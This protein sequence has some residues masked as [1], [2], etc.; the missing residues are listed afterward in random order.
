MYL[1]SVP[2]MRL[3]RDKVLETHMKSSNLGLARVPYVL[4]RVLKQQQHRGSEMVHL[5]T[6]KTFNRTVLQCNTG[7]GRQ[8]GGSI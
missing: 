6:L 8:F 4:L 3:I 7:R 2:S 1:L 5:N